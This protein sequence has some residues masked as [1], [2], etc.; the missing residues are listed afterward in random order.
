MGGVFF[1]RRCVIDDLGVFE[2]FDRVVEQRVKLACDVVGLESMHGQ[3]PRV[4]AG[5]PTSP[6]EGP[7]KEKENTPNT[8]TAGV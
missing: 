5:V 2:L 1:P 4:E 8:C 7:P 3:W 6:A